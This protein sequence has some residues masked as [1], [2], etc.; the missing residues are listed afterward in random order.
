LIRPTRPTDRDAV[1]QLVRAAF[2]SS[3]RDGEEEVEIVRQTWARE[4]Q[5]E[6]L[7]LVV[8]FDGA[9]VGHV[10]GATAELGEHSTVAVAPLSVH[11]AY[12][13]KGLGSAL[14]RSLLKEAEA[15]GWPA[16]V[17]LGSN[18]YY[19]RFG[20]EPAGPLGIFYPPIG[21]DNPHFQVC[22]LPAHNST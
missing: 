14:M 13:G 20:F 7:D 17:L 1:L 2:T 10:L 21:R 15:Q 9:V 19:S 8:Q 11:P 5:V 22:R 12:Q 6:G 3:D 18:D 4:A 16:V